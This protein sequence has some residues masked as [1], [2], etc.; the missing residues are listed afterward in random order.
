MERIPASERTREKRKALMEGRSEAEDGRS[1]LE[2][3]LEGR[4][5]GRSWSRVLRPGR[6]AWRRLSQ[7]LPAWS[8]EERGGRDRV[9]R[10]ADRRPC[11]AV[12]LAHPGDRRRPDRVVGGLGGRDVCARTFNPRHRGAV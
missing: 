12:P 6:G 9:Q 5:Q 1:E 7:R 2:E 11:G 8:G 10:A 4:S 3:A